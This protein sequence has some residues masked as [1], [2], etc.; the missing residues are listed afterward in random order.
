MEKANMPEGPECRRY[1]LALGEHI[2]GESLGSF[3]IKSGRY[4]KKDMPGIEEIRKEI[5]LKVQGVGV[6]GKLIYLIFDNKS[7]LWST[8]G[9]T[10]CWQRD[11]SKHTRAIMT[12]E[13]GK[14]A[15]FNDV[16]NFGTLKYCTD[17]KLLVSKLQSLGPDLLAEEVSNDIFIS[18]LRKN[19][20]WN[21]TKALMDQSIIAGVGNYI[22]AEALW[23]ARISPHRKVFDVSDNNMQVLNKAIQT[24]MKESFVSGGATVKSYKDF[25]GEIGNYSSRFMV[26][27]QKT[28][29]DGHEVVK[30]KTPDGRTTHW[31]PE[32]QR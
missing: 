30:E 11:E 20:D 17:P 12:F 2:G 4:L 24:V 28:D 27:N 10:G 14:K 31:V 32:V 7:S 25:F 15:Y 5:P 8:L 1:A 16:R 22:K 29:P 3:E 23:L 26:Y 21:I 13:S 19:N 9:M 6:H 18:Q